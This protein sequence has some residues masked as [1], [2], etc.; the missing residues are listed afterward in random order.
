[1]DSMNV[2]FV[3]CGEGLGHVSR[4]LKLAN[5]AKEQGIN[6]SFAT[7]GKAYSFIQ[8]RTDCPVYEIS[9]EVTLGGTGGYF[10]IG[11]TLAGIPVSL[12]KSFLTTWKIL[13]TENI[14]LV[15]C[16]TMFAAGVASKIQK[17]PVLFMTNQNYFS[18]LA[19]P[20]AWYWKV[21]GKVIRKYLS[22]VPKRVL[23]PDF[24]PPNTISEYNFMIKEKNREKYVFIGP[25]LDPGIYDAK[26]SRE[27]VFAS[28]GGES[29]NMPLYAMLKEISEMDS[30]IVVQVCSPSPGL[31]EEG[32]NFKNA[33]YVKNTFP[34][35]AQAKAAIIHGGLSTLHEAMYLGKPV[36]LIIDPY[37]PEEGNNGR[38]VEEIGCGMMIRKD[39]VTKES[40]REAILSCMKMEVCDM[41]GLYDKERGAENF[42][43]VLDE[44]VPEWKK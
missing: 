26:I 17:I 22:F 40:L 37:H 10:S 28:F 19:E 9:R 15:V 20:E 33:G 30:R 39:L 25:I 18:S 4:S 11:K 6:C 27:V 7:Y 12:A 31:P 36:L 24:A 3:V 35:I 41:R 13:K 29:F 16:D 1:M 14:D 32:V 43:R 34:Y 2:L 38:K 42:C 5:H 8:D 21:F 23:V 44:I